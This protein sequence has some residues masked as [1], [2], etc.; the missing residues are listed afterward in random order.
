M[1]Q[2]LGR[3]LTKGEVVHHINGIK[4]DN[5]K[6]NLLVMTQASHHSLTNHLAMLWLIE[7]PDKAEEA[8]RKFQIAFTSGG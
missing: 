6:E 3:K 4:N 7:H 2:M 8:S 5:R 1:E